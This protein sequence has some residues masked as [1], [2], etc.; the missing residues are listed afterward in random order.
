MCSAF[1]PHSRYDNSIITLI[2]SVYCPITMSSDKIWVHEK[3]FQPL[4]R[5]NYQ[6]PQCSSTCQVR[7]APLEEDKRSFFLKFGQRIFIFEEAQK[8]IQDVFGNVYYPTCP[9]ENCVHF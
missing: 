6:C 4:N 3:T 2:G 1:T 7:N 9:I 8:S 5:S